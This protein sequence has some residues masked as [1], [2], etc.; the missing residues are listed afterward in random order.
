MN[1]D[2]FIEMEK[3]N[4][5]EI[6]QVKEYVESLKRPRHKQENEKCTFWQRGKKQDPYSEDLSRICPHVQDV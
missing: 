2:S 6:E 1:L 3:L 4:S 5:K